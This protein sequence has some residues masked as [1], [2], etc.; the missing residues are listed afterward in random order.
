MTKCTLF[1][2][3]TLLAILCTAVQAANP[4]KELLGEF[5]AEPRMV[6]PEAPQVPAL[7]FD[8]EETPFSAI[9]PRKLARLAASGAMFRLNTIK[10]RRGIVRLV[11]ATGTAVTV[12]IELVPEEGRN[13]PSIITRS[14]RERF[15]TIGTAKAARMAEAFLE[16]L[17]VFGDSDRPS[18]LC[19]NRASRRLHL[20]RCNHLPPDSLR[21]SFADTAAAFAQGYQ[22]CNICFSID[23][24]VLQDAYIRARRKALEAARRF[25]TVHPLDADPERQRRIQELGEELVRSFPLEIPDYDYRFAVVES[26]FSNAMSFPTGFVYVSSQLY[27]AVED[28]AELEFLL[29]HELAHNMF[30]QIYYED[31][32]GVLVEPLAYEHLMRIKQT[33][34]KEADLVALALLSMR[35]GRERAAAAAAS[36]L[37]KVYALEWDRPADDKSL[38][39]STHPSLRERT[40]FLTDDL[41]LPA[42]W[43]GFRALDGD[44]SQIAELRVVARL[45]AGDGTQLLCLLRTNDLL[46]NELTLSRL[47]A[48]VFSSGFGDDRRIDQLTLRDEN[49]RKASFSLPPDLYSWKESIHRQMYPGDAFI[50]PETWHLLVF[51]GFGRACTEVDVGRLEELRF[52][53]LAGEARWE[54]IE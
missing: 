51:E 33:S 48:G 54:G 19:A 47:G 39:Y 17:F 49:G 24:R 13:G 12:I 7:F 35:L 29:L 23:E 20:Q 9:V 40:A 32:R 5:N 26:Q 28:Q 53:L 50:K 46:E 41:L 30:H 14:I 21:V 52:A 43:P 15:P 31:G 1:L 18:P 2:Q 4:L 10:E 27:D 8:E 34:E 22:L 36:I 37:R 3:A 25:E 44:G 16:D 11:V 45:A 38:K 6:R 42:V